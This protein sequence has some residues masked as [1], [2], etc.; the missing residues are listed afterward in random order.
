[1]KTSPLTCKKIS[2]NCLIKNEIINYWDINEKDHDNFKIMILK[3]VKKHINDK[4]IA[5]KF[6]YDFMVDLHQCVWNKIHEIN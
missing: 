6:S 1:M 4:L 2:D 3:I 5:E